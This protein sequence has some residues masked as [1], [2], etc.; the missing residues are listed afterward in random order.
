[1]F[2]RYFDEDQMMF[3]KYE[4]FRKNQE[5]WMNEIFNFLKVD[6]SKFGYQ[7]QEIHNRKYSHK[8]TN[9]EKTTL[10]GIYKNDIKEV[11]RLLDWDCSD[12]SIY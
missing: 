2:Q 12:W 4:A 10:R 6:K 7:P 11:E 3:V 9:E 1:M 5:N 8:M